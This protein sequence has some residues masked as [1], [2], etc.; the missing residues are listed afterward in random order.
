MIEFNDKVAS[1]EGRGGTFGGRK[2]GAAGAASTASLRT[3]SL[4]YLLAAMQIASTPRRSCAI[5]RRI[6]SAAFPAKY[7]QVAIQQ[8]REIGSFFKPFNAY[9]NTADRTSQTQH[10]N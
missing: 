4:G 10:I 8:K 1:R 9:Y 7:Q 5:A 3:V 6:R 2:A